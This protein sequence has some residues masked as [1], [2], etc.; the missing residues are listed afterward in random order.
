[1]PNLQF[2]TESQQEQ[3]RVA[4]FVIQQLGTAGTPTNPP[5]LTPGT[6]LKQVTADERFAGLLQWISGTIDEI[7]ESDVLEY[8]RT[9]GLSTVDLD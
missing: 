3:I 4:E 2:Q 7:K 9:T 1:M 5:P 8:R 6:S